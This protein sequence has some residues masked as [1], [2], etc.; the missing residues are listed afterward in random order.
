MTTTTIC[1]AVYEAARPFLAEWVECAMRAAVLQPVDA[2][3]VSDGVPDIVEILEPLRRVVSVTVIPGEGTPAEI[4]S[5]M[6][7]AAHSRGS[8]ILVL[9]DCDDCLTPD[10]IELHT[11]ALDSAD[12]SYGDM[13]IVDKDG[14]FLGTNLYE[15]KEIPEFLN[16]SSDLARRNFVGFGN[17]AIWRE[18]LRFEDCIF[19]NTVVAPD[20]WLFTKLLDRGLTGRKTSRAVGRYRQ[21]GAN[22]LGNFDGGDIRNRLIKEC[23]VAVAHFEALSEAQSHADLVT[24]IRGLQNAITAGRLSCEDLRELVNTSRPAWCE[25]AITAADRLGEIDRG[26]STN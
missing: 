26:R 20:W 5:L 11:T 17:S 2:V 4:R 13:E 1:T 23:A 7:R 12:F 22:L 15:G 14:Q 10:A 24:R 9:A 6:L 19:P 8:E 18:N 16:S 25:A 3:V 21:H